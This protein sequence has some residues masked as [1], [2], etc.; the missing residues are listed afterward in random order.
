MDG[1]SCTVSVTFAPTA[2][3]SRSATITFYDAVAGSP[4]QAVTLT[5]TGV[6]APAA[7]V[8][9]PGTNSLVFPRQAVNTT[10][11]S[12]MWPFGNRMVSLHNTGSAAISVGQVVAST[13]TSGGGSEFSLLAPYDSCSHAA[14]ISSGSSCYVYVAFSPTLGGAQTGKLTFPVTYAGTTTPTDITVALSGTGVAAQDA[15]GANPTNVY[16]VAPAAGV[17]S[18]EAPVSFSDTGN[19]AITSL[20][21]SLPA[22]SPFSIA[23]NGCTS[24]SLTP[25]EHSCSLELQFRGTASA[26]GTLTFSVTYADGTTGSSTVTLN[27][28]LAPLGSGGLVFSTSAVAFGR[29]LESTSSYQATIQLVNPTANVITLNAQ[30]SLSGTGA[31]AYQVS[32]GC[33]LA[34]QATS[35]CSITLTFAPA[36][37]GAFAA[38]LS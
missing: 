18:S 9:A 27:G 24:V 37:A 30:P 15:S 38:T 8:A 3:G 31:S 19:T 22:G 23:G 16:L 14:N 32:N 12:I 4:M 6:T 34:L 20:T 36:T 2:T 29:E 7:D 5:G 21:A 17:S 10:T 35:N 13:T 26:T 33:G 25:S 11:S 1:G 28:I